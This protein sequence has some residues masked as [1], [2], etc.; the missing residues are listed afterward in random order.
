VNT[1][2]PYPSERGSIAIEFA[3]SVIIL[4]VLVFGCIG[5]AM[6]FY[7]Y[8]VVNE[9]VRDAS[10]YAIVHGNGCIKP[11]TTSCNIAPGGDATAAAAALR[12]YLN[13][14]IYPGINGNN[15]TV[16]VAYVPGPGAVTCNATHC[17]GAGDQ[18]TVSV[19][20]PYLYNI[21]FIPSRLLNM[22]A[23]ST[24]VISQ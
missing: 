18:V 11:D 22:N 14:Q 9:Y 16:N 1:R 2:E 8:E 7:T 10:R 5:V 17:N 13:N 23:T 20:Y 4:T 3:L 19:T 6:G 12:T 24:M 15:L 21:P